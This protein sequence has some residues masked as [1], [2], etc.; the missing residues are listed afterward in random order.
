MMHQVMAV[1]RIARSASPPAPRR[2]HRA[3]AHVAP[4]MSQAH[5]RVTD[6]DIRCRA[7]DISLAIASHIECP[8]MSVRMHVSYRRFSHCRTI[9]ACGCPCAHRY[10]HLDRDRA[11]CIVRPAAS[12]LDESRSV[13]PST[14]AGRTPVLEGGG[15]RARRRLVPREWVRV[16]IS[17]TRRLHIRHCQHR[18]VECRM[19]VIRRHWRTAVDG[20]TR[21]TR[22]RAGRRAIV[23]RDDRAHEMKDARSSSSHCCRAAH[24]NRPALQAHTCES[25]RWAGDLAAAN[26]PAAASDAVRRS[27]TARRRLADAKSKLQQSQN[28][29]HNTHSLQPLVDVA[30][31]REWRRCDSTRVICTHR[32][33]MLVYV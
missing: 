2:R 16:C 7:H 21:D 19:G 28:R 20:D 1:R 23:A 33:H 5:S 27:A 13:F 24:R 29:S 26:A 15:E 32:S 14:R 25:I 9:S 30:S 3:S 8:S 10:R 12:E 11:T 17:R 31:I 22:R 6:D 4:H 18:D